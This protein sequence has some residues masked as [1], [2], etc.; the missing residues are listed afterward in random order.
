MIEVTQLTKSYAGKRGINN[1]SLH[2]DEGEIFGFLGPNGAGKTTTI[3]ILLAL[4]RADAGSARIAGLDVWQQSL[5]IKRIVGYL[6]GELS[7]DPTLTGGQLLTYLGKLRGGVDQKYLQT[8]MTRLDFDPTRRF[9]HYSTGNKR[10]LGLIQALMHR[11][12]LLVFDEPTS[13][14]DPLHQHVFEQLVREAQAEGATI[15]L[16]SHI[17]NEVEQLCQRV[18]IIRQGTVVRVGSV[19]DLKAIKQLEVTIHFAEVVPTEIFTPLPTVES[20]TVQGDGY[21]LR[22]VVRGPLDAIIKTAAQ[23]PI[24]TINSHE[25]SLE[26]V[27]LR[28]YAGDELDSTEAPDVV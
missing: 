3:R 4:L 25:P 20:V 19:A 28:Y 16:S 6:P 12:R 7:L 18:G 13:G 24:V 1:V 21:G 22:L 26:E 17:L 10:K 23:Y 8:L 11:P 5:A 14:L 15:F 2:V 27:F 9:R